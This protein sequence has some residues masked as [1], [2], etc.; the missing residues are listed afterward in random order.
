MSKLESLEILTQNIVQDLRDKGLYVGFAESCTGGLLSRVFT[1]I[2][3]VSAVFKG[4]VVSYD[5]SVKMYV[6]GVKQD[7][8][9][10]HGAVSHQCAEEM[11]NGALKVLNVDLAVSI[12]GVAGPTGG[13]ADKPVGT[14]FVAVKGRKTAEVK[15][16]KCNFGS[17]K[18]RDEIQHLSC[19]VALEEIKKTLESQF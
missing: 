4:S 6:L 5:N 3:G 15:V 18:T 2:S 14:V 1:Q 10:E 16:I 9:N 12:T 19:A 17:E 7:T 11:V 8:L 13:T